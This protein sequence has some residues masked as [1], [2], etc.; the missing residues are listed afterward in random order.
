MAE[1]PVMAKSG[2]TRFIEYWSQQNKHSL[3]TS[4]LLFSPL[5]ANRSATCMLETD[6]WPIIQSVGHSLYW[7]LKSAKQTQLVHVGIVIFS[8]ICKQISYLHARN[9]SVAYSGLQ[10]S[11]SA[12]KSGVTKT[13]ILNIE[14]YEKKSSLV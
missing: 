3:F 5:F 4:E 14:Y 7:I 8:I 9:I 13:F 11:I 10:Y 6:R 2:G 12:E 1:K